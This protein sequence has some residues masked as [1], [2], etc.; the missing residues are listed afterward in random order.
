[1]H[2][3][4]RGVEVMADEMFKTLKGILATRTARTVAPVVLA[5]PPAPAETPETPEQALEAMKK[6]LGETFHY[7]VARVFA[8][9]S[10]APEKA[11]ESY[12]TQTVAACYDAYMKQFFKVKAAGAFRV[13]LFKDDVS[14]RVNAK[15]LF[16]AVPD[17]PYGYYL[18]ARRALVMNIATGGG[19]LVHEMFHALVRADFPGIPA[20]ANE[21]IASLF[22]QCGVTPAGTLEGYVNWR[23]PILQDAIKKGTL[24]SFRRIMTMT[25]AE[26]YNDRQGK[27]AAAR[28]LMLYLQEKDLLVK[29]YHAFRDRTPEDKTGVKFVEELLGRKLEDFE[30]EWR[31]WALA[32][33]R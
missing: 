13:Y 16:G 7:R 15:K 2:P 4:A 27:Y 23:L 19:T 6:E 18:D 26:F 30:P 24:P 28:Y 8:V 31:K 20:W 25:D 29:F 14:Y 32:L 3:S 11:L 9:A 5:A 1:M 22:E 10:D 12:C 33:K 21:G 17:T